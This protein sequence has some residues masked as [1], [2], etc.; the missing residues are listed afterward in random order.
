MTQTL[1]IYSRILHFV[2]VLFGRNSYDPQRT[3]S[4]HLKLVHAIDKPLYGISLH[5]F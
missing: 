1:N 2:I 4:T 3:L 5:K